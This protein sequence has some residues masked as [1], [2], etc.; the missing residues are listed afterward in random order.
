MPEFIAVPL[1][2]LL[3]GLVFVILWAADAGLGA[4]LA[5]G[6]V[7]LV[8]LVVG[9][10]VAVRRPRGPAALEDATGFDGGAAPVDD[11]VHRV[12]LLVDASCSASDV[13]RL[14]SGQPTEVFVVAP[15]LSSRLDR[16]TGDEQ[17]YT[18]AEEHLEQTLGALRGVG[19][20]A[21]GH[22]GA[23][24]P[25]QAADDGLREFAADEVVFALAG[26][27]GTAW[28]ENG[29]VDAARDRYSVP[30]RRLETA[31]SDESSTDR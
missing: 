3:L 6:G 18:S 31:G 26:E 2:V 29:V 1:V 20:E 30:V 22:V 19:L 15:A 13:Q 21:R 7:L 14:V 17:A 11:D 27:Q 10:V 12:L 4:W 5:V 9:A 16:W 28:L 23:H 25:L 24:D 8:L